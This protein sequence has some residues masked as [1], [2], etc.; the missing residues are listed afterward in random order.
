MLGKLDMLQDAKR[1]NCISGKD[2]SEELFSPSI[3][4]SLL[5]ERF[6]TDR[7]CS[8]ENVASSTVPTN[9][10]EWR[11]RVCSWVKF[12]ICGG[13]S[14]EKW[15]LYKANFVN[16]LKFPM[17]EGMGPDKLQS[18]NWRTVREVRFE[19]HDGM[20]P[21]SFNPDTSNKSKDFILPMEDGS[22]PEKPPAPRPNL[23]RDLEVADGARY[24]TREVGS[25][26]R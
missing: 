9:M 15:Q 11:R 23:F 14:P 20:D 1:K 4:T 22:I 17:K 10:F 3:T 25:T 2:T 5:F 13:T 12:F 16:S 19:I 7:F 6:R 26:D 8:F 24:C 21:T 18:K